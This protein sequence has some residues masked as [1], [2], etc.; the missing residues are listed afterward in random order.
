LLLAADGSMRKTMIPSWVW[1]G[2]G[3]SVQR[4]GEADRLV[5]VWSRQPLAEA[6]QERI[7]VP[8]SSRMAREMAGSS[9]LLSSY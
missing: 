8:A 4:T 7:A 1:Y 9:C 2:G 3:T 5:V 6:G